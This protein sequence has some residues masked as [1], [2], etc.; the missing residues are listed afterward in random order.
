MKKLMKTMSRLHKNERGLT[1][2]KTVIILIVITT[3]SAACGYAVQSAGLFPV[4][5][6]KEIYVDLEQAK[7]T[8]V[9]SVPNR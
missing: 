2:L 7:S 3:V 8:I 9:F 4:E 1:G 6:G 5:R